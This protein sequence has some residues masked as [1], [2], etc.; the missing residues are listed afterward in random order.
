MCDPPHGA[1]RVGGSQAVQRLLHV[2]VQGANGE[3]GFYRVPT[4]P[5]GSPKL[6]I[7]NLAACSIG[8][9]DR[10]ATVG[11][12][13]LPLTDAKVFC[14]NF[15]GRAFAPGVDGEDQV[16]QAIARFDDGMPCFPDAL[17]PA[18]AA[19]A[20]LE[21][22][23]QPEPPSPPLTP[24]DLPPRA[25]SPTI[26]YTPQVLASQLWSSETTS[27]CLRRPL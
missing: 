8:F 6:I 13:N 16:M 21:V 12:A 1:P 19:P 15:R 25:A 18:I 14:I 3:G 11:P 26:F 20:P 17:Q 5:A 4:N 10:V 23:P 24:A 9:L 22:A 7:V 2:R 27:P